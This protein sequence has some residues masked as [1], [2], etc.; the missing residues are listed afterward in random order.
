MELS[1]MQAL[2]Y[3]VRDLLLGLGQSL[4][5][6][7]IV[8]LIALVGVV[9]AVGITLR[10]LRRRQILD[11]PNERSLHR[12]PTP[13][14]GGIGVIIGISP[15]MIAF[16]YGMVRSSQVG[17]ANLAMSMGIGLYLLTLVSFIDDRR[18]LS[19]LVRL[20]VQSLCCFWL[21]AAI[22]PDYRIASELVP[23]WLERL[24]LMLALVWFINLYNFMDG[25]DGITAIETLSL[26]LGGFMSVILPSII[27]VILPHYFTVTMPSFFD[28]PPILMLQPVIPILSMVLMAA[29]I[30]FLFYNWSPAKIFLG[31]SGSIPLGFLSG[32]LLV[33]LVLAGLWQTAI[34]LPLYYWLDASLTLIHRLKRGEKLWLAHRV[35]F[36][37]RAVQGGLSHAQVARAILWVNLGLILL[38]CASLFI[39][40]GLALLAGFALVGWRLWRFDRLSPV[41]QRFLHSQPESSS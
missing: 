8:W 38:A 1:T 34:L 25:I 37:Q 15:I 13:R 26:G 23:I 4:L 17:L 3:A 35:H 5:V 32:F 36:Y 6:F 19:P 28:H 39:P 11:Q 30:G 18:S 10:I 16:I 14:G 20:L 33:C 29:G 22:S 21:V 2:G 27:N 31:D 24:V 41:T 12:V 7:G 40:F 9:L